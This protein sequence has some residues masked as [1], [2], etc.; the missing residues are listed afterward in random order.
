MSGLRRIG[1]N[2]RRIAID[3]PARGRTRSTARFS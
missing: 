1:E 2:A 3:R